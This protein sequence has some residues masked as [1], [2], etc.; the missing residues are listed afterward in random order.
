MY[1]ITGATGNT[2]NPIA[3]QLLDAGKEVTVI[4]R[5]KERLSDLVEKG[6]VPAEGDLADS[7]FLTETFEGADA[8]YAV[9]PPNFTA[10]NFRGYQKR[11][12]ESLATALEKSKVS[13]VVALSSIGAHLKEGA[14]VVQGL[15]FMEQRFNQINDLNALYLR[16]TF[17]MENFYGQIPLIKQMN[18]MG[19]AAD[20]DLSIPMIATRDI[21]DYAAKR[22][23]TLD[24]EGH[25][26]HY[27][28][29]ERDVTFEE[30]TKIL[31]DAIGKP[32]LNYVSFSY[33]EAKKGIMEQGA[34]QDLADRYNEF[35]RSLNAGKINE[36]AERT[37]ETT[38][39]TSIEQFAKEFAEVYKNS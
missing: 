36:D 26:H 37:P 3:H 16:P 29:G 11:I 19:F 7:N 8:V 12:A 35:F 39:P 30:A 13:H 2:G 1:V 18:I 22:L 20:R 34:S 27:L 17:F 9:I 32:D 28:L 33:E 23:L 25:S 14:G 10:D 6:A 31:G 4:S 21:A 15:H 24:F 38:T 5:N